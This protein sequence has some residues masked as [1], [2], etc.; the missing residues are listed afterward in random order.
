MKFGIFYQHQLPRPWCEGAEHRLLKE[1]VEQVELAD[2]LGIHY[3]WAAEH[4]FLEEY[5]HSSAPEVFL[6]AC[7]QVTERIR[8]GHGIMHLP[9]EFNH[10]ARVAERIA[11]LDLLSDG[12]VEFGTGEASSRIEL[13]GFEIDR[14]TKREQWAEAVDA[15]ARMFVEEPFA[16]Y[17]GKHFRMPPR[18]V[19]PKPMQAPH[20][21]M[22][23]ACSRRETIRVAAR[24]G[25]G[26]LCFSFVDP[27]EAKQWVEEYY[28]TI[29]SESCVAAGLAVNPNIAVVMPMMLHN[30]ETEA[31]RRGRDGARF[32][33]FGLGHY[34]AFGN[35]RPGKTDL[36]SEYKSYEVLADL[37][38]AGEA[39]SVEH[40]AHGFMQH[41]GGGWQSCIG[42]PEKARSMLRAYAEAGVDQVIFAVQA[43]HNEHA[44]ICESMQLFAD[45]VMPEF[46]AAESDRQR[47]KLDRYSTAMNAALARRTAPPSVASNYAVESVPN[48]SAPRP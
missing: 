47:V 43:G 41:F 29:D 1:S 2:R 13:D 5:G 16:G 42:T 44:H 45:E 26:A 48:S 11:T 4:H 14:A 33:A 19:L 15:V 22:W 32:F 9:P 28:S 39:A 17:S 20:P 31:I 12:R 21:P 37:S 40:P 25:M 30:D 36:W 24:S 3:V 7:S 46:V 38:L 34:Y 8:L 23:V 27:A 6:A 35:H 18:N 10:T